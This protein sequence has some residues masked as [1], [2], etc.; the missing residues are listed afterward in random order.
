M[1]SRNN[2]IEENPGTND[3]TLI[4]NCFYFLSAIVAYGCVYLYYFS[5]ELES[6][7]T[8]HWNGVGAAWMSCADPVIGDFPFFDWVLFAGGE[9]ILMCEWDTL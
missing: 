9:Y 7:L 3:T 1:V 4:Q 6:T 5:T 2:Y 8:V